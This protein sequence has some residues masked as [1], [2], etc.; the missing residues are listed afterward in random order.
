MGTSSRRVLPTLEI[1]M[2]KKGTVSD[3][4]E[5]T[6]NESF[7]NDCYKSFIKSGNSVRVGYKKQF[8]FGLADTLE[9]GGFTIFKLDFCCSDHFWKQLDIITLGT[10]PKNCSESEIG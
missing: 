8:R 1:S 2:A 6:L 3:T 5:K 7:N 9:N 4:R 10:K